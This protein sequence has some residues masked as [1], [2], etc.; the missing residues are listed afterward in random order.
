MSEKQ[1]QHTL[2]ERIRFVAKHYRE[3]RLDAEK[4]WR[5]FAV[6][7]Q[8]RSTFHLPSWM[9]R[10]VA[11]LLLAL[12]C[13]VYV[14][15]N[16]QQPDWVVIAAAPTQIKEVLLPDSSKVTLDAAAELR[17]DARSF[18]KAS[19]S[20]EMKGKAFYQVKHQPELPFSVATRTTK[21]TVLGT[22][23]LVR[24]WNQN[25]EVQVQ[26]GRVRFEAGTDLQAT[27]T[28]GMSAH[29]SDGEQEIRTVQE[30]DANRNALSW[31]SRELVF[32]DAPLAKVIHDLEVCYN[33]QITYPEHSPDSLRLTATFRQMDLEQVL[34]VIN[35]TL[36]ARLKVEK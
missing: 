1:T 24:E 27:L 13:G 16:R 36:D 33:V 15:W 28:A 31:Q 19:R 22:T 12:G 7:H 14:I 21:V 32:R 3:G 5:K 29:Y 9:W 4:A 17:Y 25:V 20:V 2:E 10:A 11:V 34:L 18:G 23:F 35:Q 26:T 30:A 8:I 6:E